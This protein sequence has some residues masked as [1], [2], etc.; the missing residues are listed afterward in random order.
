M[1]TDRECTGSARLQPRL[2]EHNEEVDS[3]LGSGAHP[4]LLKHIAINK[5]NGRDQH[6]TEV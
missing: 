4:A 6:G 3:F 1:C 5:A 2:R